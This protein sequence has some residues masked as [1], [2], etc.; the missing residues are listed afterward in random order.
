LVDVDPLGE[1]PRFLILRVYMQMGNAA[2]ASGELENFRRLLEREGGDEPSA[3]LRAVLR[4][5]GDGK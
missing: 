2:A 1:S 4:V 3:A 5:G